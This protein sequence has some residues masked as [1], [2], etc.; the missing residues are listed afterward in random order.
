MESI[1]V[2]RLFVVAFD[3]R[4][5]DLTATEFAILEVFLRYPEYVRDRASLIE[6]AYDFNMHVSDRT[7]DSHI[8]HIRAKFSSVGCE[9][10]IDTV[11]GVGYRLGQCE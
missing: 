1:M 7:V 11:H 5:I 6:A 4:A 10:I 2:E 8:R 9:S 3:E